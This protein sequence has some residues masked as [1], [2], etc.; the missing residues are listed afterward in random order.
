QLPFPAPQEPD[1]Q[2]VCRR[3]AYRNRTGAG[4]RRAGDLPVSAGRRAGPGEPCSN[5]WRNRPG[6]LKV[7]PGARA[8][9]LLWRVVEEVDG[10]PK[11]FLTFSP[12]NFSG[13]PPHPP[14]PS[15]PR[16]PP[17]FSAPPPPPQPSSS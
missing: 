9:R 4:Y 10:F 1:V 5:A 15:T 8:P 17:G 12:G 13:N 16:I 14:Q 6:A 11:L 2:R 7:N 3:G